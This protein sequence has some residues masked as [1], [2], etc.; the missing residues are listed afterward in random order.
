MCLSRPYAPNRYVSVL[1]GSNPVKV[2]G[3]RGQTYTI[4]CPITAMNDTEVYIY[5]ASIIQSIG[6]I[7]GFYPGYVD[8]SH[9]VKLTEL[10]VGS[11]VSGY[12]NTNMTDFAVG[13]NTLLEHLNLQNVPNLKKGVEY[14]KFII[15]RG[16]TVSAGSSSCD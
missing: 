7:S 8:F 9:G 15:T 10:K 13:N 11:G 1:Y 6:D 2:R 5:N 14:G 12:K 3:K 16:R 4:E